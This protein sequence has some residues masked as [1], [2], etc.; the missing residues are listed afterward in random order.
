[1]G[2]VGIGIGIDTV[3]YIYSWEPNKVIT[4]I[5]YKISWNIL[6][7]T[8]ML[9]KVLWCFVHV[10]FVRVTI[11]NIVWRSWRADM[12]P[13]A[14]FFTD[15]CCVI[16]EG[17]IVVIDIVTWTKQ[18]WIKH[19]N[20]VGTCSWNMVIANI[21][22]NNISGVGTYEGKILCTWWYRTFVWY[23]THIDMRKCSHISQTF[24]DLFW[25]FFRSK[26]TGT[27]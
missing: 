2:A 20:T 22:L 8:Q 1:M 27:N 14:H 16:Q 5:K 4:V 9:K 11:L 7:P 10:C 13:C 6:F 17:V 23:I 26:V 18:T 24:D 3:T 12:L 21:W 25:Q 15:I 19:H